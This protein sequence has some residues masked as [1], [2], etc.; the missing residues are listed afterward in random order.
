MLFRSVHLFR[1]R[2]K[3]R[4]QVTAAKLTIPDLDPARRFLA[5][6]GRG[7]RSQIHVL[8]RTIS[9]GP[10]R[11]EP[12]PELLHMLRTT[13]FVDSRVE[14]D[15]RKKLA[16]LCDPIRIVGIEFGRLC[17]DDVFSPESEHSLLD[18]V[19]SFDG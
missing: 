8:G 10:S 15:K 3:N 4:Q 9:F 14:R 11:D 6:H 7:A 13:A 18:G 17:G 19:L 1:Y 16:D 12:R 2:G 5:S